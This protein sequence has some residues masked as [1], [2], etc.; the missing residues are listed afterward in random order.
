[1][2]TQAAR[3]AGEVVL[4][5]VPT[6]WRNHP[7][8]LQQARYWAGENEIQIEYRFDRD[9]L[10]VRIDGADWPHV[11][12]GDCSASQVQLEIDGIQRTYVV[13]LTEEVAYVDSSL[14]ATELTVVPRFRVPEDD[15]QS[16]SL[17]APFPGVVVEVKVQIGDR[18]AAGDTLL[19]IESM[20]MLHSVHAPASGQVAE[21]RVEP[22]GHVELGAI[23]AVIETDADELD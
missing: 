14:G 2:A 13:H 22:S 8:Q 1:M 6:G 3:R 12:L 7:S 10:L 11:R 19:V 16:G 4:P 18:V 23:L 17:V 15:I 5:S 21:I 20:K 9:Q